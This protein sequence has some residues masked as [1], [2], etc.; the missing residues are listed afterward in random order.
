MLGDLPVNS[1]LRPALIRAK[2]LWRIDKSAGFSGEKQPAQ[3]VV[4]VSG[5]LSIRDQSSIS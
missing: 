1:I 3:H 2:S 4:A 5:W